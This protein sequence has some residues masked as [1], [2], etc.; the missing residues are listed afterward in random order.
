MLLSS[1]KSITQIGT[2]VGY[3][4]RRYFTKVFQKYTG[5]IP[6]GISGKTQAEVKAVCIEGLNAT[7]YTEGRILFQLRRAYIFV[8]LVKSI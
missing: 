8:I 1:D 5:E 3:P 6:S 7:L 4:N 2:A